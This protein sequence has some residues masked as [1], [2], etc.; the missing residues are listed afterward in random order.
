MSLATYDIGDTVTLPVTFKVGTTVTDPTT[1]TL[2]VRKP[3]GTTT[4]Y[5]YAGGQV[6]KDSTGVYHYNLALDQAGDWEAEWVGTGAVVATEPVTLYVRQSAVSSSLLDATALTTL[7]R[8]RLHVLR[9]AADD[10]AD[11]KLA[12]YINWASAA[13]AAYARNVLF[14]E[15]LAVDDEARTLTLSCEGTVNLSPFDLRSVTGAEIT[16]STGATSTLDDATY[17]LQ[18]RNA[19]AE[20]TYLSLEL[21]PTASVY[22]AWSARWDP[23]TEVTITGDWGMSPVPPHV[24]GACLIMVD[25]IF[26]NPTGFSQVAMGPFSATEP[27]ETTSTVPIGGLPPAARRLLDLM[28]RGRTFGSVSVARRHS[29]YGG[30]P[31]V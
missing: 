22:S 20:G 14:R 10:S 26:K 25:D 8:A 28:R 21:L 15:I 23:S 12:L 2:R 9:N 19:T 13:V 29:S 17:R 4:S 3:S 27:F 16:Y 30:L 1:V 7:H 6:Q 24:E 18:P 31:T 5:T 11:D